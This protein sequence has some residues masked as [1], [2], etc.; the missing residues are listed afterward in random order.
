ME[1]VIRDSVSGQAVEVIIKTGYTRLWLVRRI[2]LPVATKHV[3]IIRAPLPITALFTKHYTNIRRI[4]KQMF[5]LTKY[6]GSIAR[7]RSLST[8]ICFEMHLKAKF[9]VQSNPA[10]F[11]DGS[12]CSKQFQGRVHPSNAG[13]I[14]VHRSLQLLLGVFHYAGD[15]RNAPAELI[16]RRNAGNNNC[17]IFQ[18]VK[19]YS[20][21]GRL[22]RTSRVKRAR[23]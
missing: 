15:V 7:R 6:I 5:S 14:C 11:C 16:S 3:T 9:A 12:G 17:A 2:L 4:S 18:M 23:G 8:G 20:A 19:S 10:I 22:R 21:I 1:N 13:L